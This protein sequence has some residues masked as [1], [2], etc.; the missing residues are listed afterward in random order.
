[1]ITT[2][3]PTKMDC[4]NIYYQDICINMHKL[5]LCTFSNNF[6]ICLSHRCNSYGLNSFIFTYGD[7][8]SYTSLKTGQDLKGVS[9][10]LD[11]KT[12][13]IWYH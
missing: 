6:Y 10:V 1:M 3:N 4:T 2:V 11:K 8:L 13:T 12:L 9:C 7:L 5:T